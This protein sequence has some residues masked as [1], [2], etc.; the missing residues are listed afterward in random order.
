MGGREMCRGQDG[1]GRGG[2]QGRNELL[3]A[4]LPVPAPGTDLPRPFQKRP[5]SPG[6]EFPPILIS[7]L[8]ACCHWLH[9]RQSRQAPGSLLR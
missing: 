5:G 8:R 6:E 2:Q 1:R 4:S 3:R 9:A 7:G